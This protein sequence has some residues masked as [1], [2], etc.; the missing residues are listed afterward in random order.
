M[1][2]SMRK[3]PSVDGLVGESGGRESDDDPISHFD[4]SEGGSAEGDEQD[5][6]GDRLTLTIFSIFFL[7]FS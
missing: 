5:V 1:R 4:V 7:F 3:R 2:L 6:V